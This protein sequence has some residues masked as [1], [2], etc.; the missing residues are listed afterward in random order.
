MIKAFLI[1]LFDTLVYIDEEPYLAFRDEMARALGIECGEFRK[2]WR[3]RT[4]DRFLGKI[5]DTGEMLAMV[6]AHFGV[7][8]ADG[9]KE[10]LVL[11][12]RERLLSYSHL[13]PG[14]MEALGAIR[15]EGFKTALV[16]NASNNSLFIA[17]HLG[18]VPCFDTLVISCELGV[19]K[20][21]P[22]IYREALSR[23]RIG[24]DEALFIGD[25]ACEELDGAHRLGIYTARIVQEPQSSL[26]GKSSHCDFEI[27]TLAEALALARAIR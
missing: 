1:D 9:I 8:V 22:A 20:P 25:G 23:L 18:L 4:P 15:S 27:G 3:A 14:V 11:E 12:E 17:E 7:S 6:G 21:D 13:Y 2:V 26:F 5:R 19:S 24:P 10:R 16:S